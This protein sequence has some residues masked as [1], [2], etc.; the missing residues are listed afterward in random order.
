METKIS[1]TRGNLTL[2]ST[3]LP[4]T[5]YEKD[6]SLVLIGGIP[7]KF[8]EALIQKYNESYDLLLLDV[9][10]YSNE[11]QERWETMNQTNHK[12]RFAQYGPYNQWNDV[13]DMLNNRKEKTY[14]IEVYRQVIEQLKEQN[15]NWPLQCTIVG[16]SLGCIGVQRICRSDLKP[17]SGVYIVP[18]IN[19]QDL[20]TSSCRQVYF[21]ASEDKVLQFTLSD[22]IINLMGT[23]QAKSSPDHIKEMITC[24]NESNTNYVMHI[25]GHQC[26]GLAK[27]SAQNLEAIASCIHELSY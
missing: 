22:E 12:E 8:D 3:Y 10:G 11:I 14:E 1:V 7:N 15:V 24:L 17:K 16:L 2:T 27:N 13:K 25:L 19:Y 18:V 4:C 6:G 26:H 20:K 9:Y 21:I 23:T 5:A